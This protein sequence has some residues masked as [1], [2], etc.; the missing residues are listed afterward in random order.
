M[1]E[2]MYL[3][4]MSE[5]DIPKKKFNNPIIYTQFVPNQEAYD[6]VFGDYKSIN[7]VW[8]ELYIFIYHSKA[9]NRKSVLFG[10]IETQI[11]PNKILGIST[12]KA[13]ISTSLSEFIEITQP[14]F[15]D[16]NTTDNEIKEEWHKHIVAGDT[17][18]VK[19]KQEAIIVQN[20]LNRVLNILS[21][22]ISGMNGDYVDVKPMNEVYNM[23]YTR[24]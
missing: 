10:P 6:E 16:D 17:P 14:K 22:Y 1:I 15:I 4:N 11:K 21:K 20:D 19:G 12:N 13:L 23:L 3:E 2:N 18:W 24:V 9:D 5:K 7:D 8:D